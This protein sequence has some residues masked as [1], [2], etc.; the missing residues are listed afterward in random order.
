MVKKLNWL[1]YLD[2]KIKLPPS[3]FK[4][5][6][7][8][9]ISALTNT[10]NNTTI[11]KDF[12][13]SNDAILVIN[14]LKSFWWKIDKVLD[15]PWAYSVLEIAWWIDRMKDCDKPIYLWNSWL[16]FRIAMMLAS[17]WKWKY[18]LVW[19]ERMNKR[20]IFE[21]EKGLLNLW[22]KIK[23]EL[24]YPP[25]EISWNLW[26]LEWW[27]VFISWRET[28]QFHTALLLWLAQNKEWL[29][30]KTDNLVSKNYI[31]M[32]RQLIE[33][34]WIK[35]DIN[36]AYN[37]FSIH[38]NQNFTY[39][40]EVEI[41][42]DLIM[43]TNFLFLTSMVWWKLCVEIPEEDLKSDKW[44]L[45]L[46]KNHFDCSI[47]TDNWLLKVE[48]EGWIRAFDIDV[49]DIPFLVPNIAISSLLAD[50]KCCIR[51]AN[52]SNNK[53]TKRKDLTI[54]KV[55]RKLWASVDLTENDIIITP[56]KWRIDNIV[57]T[58]EEHWND[59]RIVMALIMLSQYRWVNIRVEN[60][61]CI[62]KSFPQFINVL[63]QIW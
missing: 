7:Q 58:S 47:K 53:M 32:T 63:D 38:P 49:Y 61:E 22:V 27:E 36:E 26:K 29:I 55:L 6:R 8:L 10:W 52:S 23:T 54:P 4:S 20:T 30:L 14:A 28:S 17:L 48:S 5:I 33:K 50:W 40:K 35:V 2:S 62:N 21:M 16:W 25:C 60:I 37:Q 1:R 41:K 11:L 46:L 3:Q 13:L 31:E 34:N 56:P 43:A 9:V 15:N 12:S 24:W 18:K 59:H 57:I 51:N 42:T 45:N 19:D 39:K 44:V